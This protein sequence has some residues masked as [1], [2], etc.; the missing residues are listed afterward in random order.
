MRVE[1][2]VWERGKEAV[3]IMKPSMPFLSTTDTIII[4]RKIQVSTSFT[5]RNQSCFLCGETF[6]TT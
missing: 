4:S 2:E 5:K 1:I 6:I 3:K